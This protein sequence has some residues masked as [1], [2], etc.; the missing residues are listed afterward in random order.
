MLSDKELL[1]VQIASEKLVRPVTIHVSASQVLDTFGASM[2]NVG[3]QI[4]G[5]TMNRI[6]IEDEEDAPFVG[7]PSL[8]LS[9]EGQ[10]NIHYLAVPEG[11]EFGPF[12]DA[13][14]WLGRGKDVPD[15]HL[16]EP[17]RT[18]TEQVDILVLVAAVCPHCPHAVRAALGLAVYQP[19]IKVTVAD[20][21]Q[22]PDLVERFKVKSTPTTIVNGALTIVG[23]INV[24]Q[25]VDQIVSAGQTAT[26][27][28]TL[29]SMIETGRAEDAGSL[30]SKAYDPSAILPLYTAPEFALRMGSLV[31]MEAALEAAP[32]SLD[33]I[34][35]DLTTLLTHDEVGLRGDTA[36]L[37]G[38]IG[39]PA[40]IPALNQAVLDTDP[41]VREAA[42][43]ALDILK[44]KEA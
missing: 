19:S 3:R 41:D 38:K 25:L 21:L 15:G 7:K 44:E 16:Y 5:V 33:S 12:L 35:D 28:A 27:T 13:V 4:S 37:L 36:E 30:L 23:Q 11:H 10:K 29:R 34:V 42:I 40:A 32:R 1:Q 43:E 8:T 9:A 26:I 31:A 22:F 18:V 39:N 17:L 6:L 14:Q 24:A 2:L 20:A